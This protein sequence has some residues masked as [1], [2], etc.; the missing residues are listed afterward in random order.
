MSPKR[1]APESYSYLTASR[2]LCSN[3]KTHGKHSALTKVALH[4][5]STAVGL[6]NGFRQRES[7]AEALG[8]LGKAAAV[9]ALEDVIQI[10][11]MDTGAIVPDANLDRSGEDLPL[12][13]DGIPGL[14]MV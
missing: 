14:C 8:V 13:T 2:Q 7:Q 1:I 5:D 3:R 11:R 6:H 12:Q 9:E 10:L 4:L